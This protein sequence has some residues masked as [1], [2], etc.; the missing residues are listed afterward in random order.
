MPLRQASLPS[1]VLMTDER[2]GEALWEALERLPRGAAVIFRHYDLPPK[3]RRAL[4]ERVR[5]VARRRGLSLLLAGS[6]RQAVAWKADG[7]HDRSPHRRSSRPL[8]RSAPVHDRAGLRAA[9]H[10]DLRLVSPVYATR[11]HPGQ[12]ALGI[13]RL[14]LLL[15]RERR[16]IVALGG[17]TRERARALRIMGITRWAAIDGLTRR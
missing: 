15:G 8:L 14:G 4:Y 13:V 11:S 10:A 2:M 1:I 16:G 17:M 3:A 7:A 9:R 5:A 12:R 6:S